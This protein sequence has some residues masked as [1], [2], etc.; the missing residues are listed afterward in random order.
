MERTIRTTKWTASRSTTASRSKGSRRTSA[1]AITGTLNV[2][3]R[4][5]GV[6]SSMELAR[7]FLS[8][9]A[10]PDATYSKQTQSKNLR[11]LSKAFE[12]DA[13]TDKFFNRPYARTTYKGNLTKRYR[14]ILD[15][16]SRFNPT[17]I[18]QFLKR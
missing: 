1:P 5:S 17:S 16:E 4:A 3:R 14:R 2:Q 8:R 13:L 7:H 18:R 9:F 15:K 10:Y 12:L 6:V 11:D